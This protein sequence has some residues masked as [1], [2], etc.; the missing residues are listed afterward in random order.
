M[1][2]GKINDFISGNRDRAYTLFK[3]FM[4]FDRPFL[5]SSDLWDELKKYI[6]ESGDKSILSSP[7]GEMIVKSQEATVES[8]WLYFAVRPRV[9]RWLYARIHIE[10]LTAEEVDAA[11]FLSFKEKFVTGNIHEMDW[12]L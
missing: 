7:L 1:M 12:A 4:A 10:L 8:P 5:L 9:A 2:L 3:G 11:E 6:D